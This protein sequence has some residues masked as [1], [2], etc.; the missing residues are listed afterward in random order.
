MNRN[1]RN[2]LFRRIAIV[3]AACS[4]GWLVPASM[5]VAESGAHRKPPPPPSV[6]I[7]AVTSE[8]DG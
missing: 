5:A 6:E 1:S 8:H 7:V 4:L 2:T 3:A